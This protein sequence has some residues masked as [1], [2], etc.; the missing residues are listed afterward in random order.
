MSQRRI[1]SLKTKSGY[2]HREHRSKKGRQPKGKWF[3]EIARNKDYK[4]KKEKIK[5]DNL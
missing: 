3:N 5:F 1:K 4:K 2:G